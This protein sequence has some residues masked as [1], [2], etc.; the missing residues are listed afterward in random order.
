MFLM[1]HF[2]S[3]S[4]DFLS[5]RKSAKKQIGS[6]GYLCHCPSS[7]GFVSEHLELCCQSPLL[8][9]PSDGRL[10]LWSVLLYLLISLVLS[11]LMRS[12]GEFGN[13]LANTCWKCTQYHLVLDI[14]PNGGGLFTGA[15]K[16]GPPIYGL[17]P[18][19]G[20]IVG[21]WKGIEAFQVCQILTTNR[22]TALPLVL[23]WKQL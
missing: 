14:W 12:W 22:E 7:A 11:A 6:L 17:H 19:F 4:L 2:V 1:L 16:A 18:S 5:L 13:G 15:A 3:N 10:W 8:R 20:S 23:F 9:V 21:S